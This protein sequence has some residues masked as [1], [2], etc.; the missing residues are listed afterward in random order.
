MACSKLA[1]K[2]HCQ[3]TAVSSRNFL[4]HVCQATLL[5]SRGRH[6]RGRSCLPT[7]R[8]K[9]GIFDFSS[10]DTASMM[11]K[12]MLICRPA[13]SASTLTRSIHLATSPEA[14]VAWVVDAVMV[15]VAVSSGATRLSIRLRPPLLQCREIPKGGRKAAEDCTVEWRCRARP[16]MI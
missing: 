16:G 5:R 11:P 3:G 2:Q 13:R 9:E 4:G 12:A 10:N 1:S 7:R 14:L 6:S 8:P 15:Y